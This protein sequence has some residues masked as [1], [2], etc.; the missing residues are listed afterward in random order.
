MKVSLIIP[1]HNEEKYLSN[2]LRA[3]LAMKYP[4]FEI[5]VVDNASTDKTLEI[6]EKFLGVKVVR[7]P[8]KGSQHARE[9]GRKEATGEIIANMDADCEPDENWLTRG[10]DILL[11]KKAVAVTGPNDYFDGSKTFRFTALY[12]QKIFYSA[13]NVILVFMGKG[14]ILLGGNCI[15]RSDALEQIGGY[16]TSILFYGDDTDTAKRLSK[17][18]KI[19]FDNSLVMKSSARRFQRLGIARTELIYIYHFLK[20]LISKSKF[21]KKD[22]KDEA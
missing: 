15:M 14:G 10:V 2:T 4:D 21:I 16:D 13:I 17:L 12:I 18:G 19:I 11:S 22:T 9:R 5:I 8:N 1:A 7:E 6:A 3:A 20:V